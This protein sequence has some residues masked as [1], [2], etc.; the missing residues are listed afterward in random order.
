MTKRAVIITT[1]VMVAIVAILTILFGF[2][3]RVRNIQVSYSEEFKYSQQIDEILKV[4][5]IDK[6]DSIF[7]VN[8]NKVINNIERMYP[9]ARVEAVNLS[10]TGVKLT[11]SNRIPLYYF[12]ENEICYILDEG[13]KVLEVLSL[14]DY[15]A[16][17]Q[18]LILLN[19]VFSAGE[20]VVAGQFLNNKFTATCNNLY[21]ALYSNAVL[22]I[23]DDADLDGEA[24][25]K[26]LNREDMCNV[27]NELKFTQVYELHGQVDKLVMATSYGCNITIIE[28]QQQ[29]DLKINMAFSALRALI[30]NDK[31]E[32]LDQST[33]GTISVRYSYDTNNNI[34][35]V[36]EYYTE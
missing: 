32:G 35:P 36:V 15:N 8:R 26:Y 30:A 14:D 22:N 5:K 7:S 34:T 21:K 1:S 4:A 13:C 33:K 24:D 12:A 31:A 10:P 20:K 2:V 17:G 27:I 25:E 9:Y 28:P 23:G 11:L 19:N 18:K 3:F 6:N 16:L 29:L